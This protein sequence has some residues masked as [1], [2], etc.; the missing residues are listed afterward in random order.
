MRRFRSLMAVMTILFL[1]LA[2]FQGTA[3]AQ[4]RNLIGAN[5]QKASVEIDGNILDAEAYIVDGRTLVP[6][7]KIFET[8][9]CVIDWNPDTWTVTATCATTTIVLTVDEPTAHKNGQPVTLAVPPVLIDSR[10]FVPLRFVSEAL[11]AEVGWEQAEWKA[12][13]KTGGDCAL[14]P[15]QVHEGDIKPGGETWGRCGSPHVVKGTFYVQGADSPILS[16]QEGAVVRFAAGASIEV[17]A[18]APGGLMVY[19]TPNEPIVFTADTSGPQAGFWKGIR[20]YNQALQNNTA[21]ENARFEYAGERE[22]GALYIEGWEKTTEVTLKNVE[23]KNSLYAGLHMADQARLRAGSHGININGT[24]VAGDEG[25]FPIITAVFGSHNLP[26]GEFKGNAVNAV[27]INEQ[28]GSSATVAANTT[29]R[30]IS[31]PYAISQDVW[32]EGNASPTLTIEPGVITLWDANAGLVVGRHAPGTLVADGAARPE[33][34]GEWFTRP[35]GGGEWRVGKPELDLGLNLANAKSLEPGCALC[36]N[37]RAIVF[38]AWTSSPDRGAWNGVQIMGQAGDKSLLNGVVI[39]YAGKEEDYNAG[40]YAE[41]TAGRAVKFQLSN[42]MIAGAARSGMEFYG[43]V[44]IKEGSTGNYFVN[45]GWPIRM[46][47]D[48]VGYLPAGQTFAENDK[49]VISIW[50]GG[51]S[52]NLTKTATWRNHGIPYRMETTVYIGGTASPVLT[53]E[54]GTELLFVNDTGITVGSSEGMGSLVAVGAAGKPIKF[55]GESG[56]AGAWEGLSFTGEAGAGNRLEMVTIEYA[57][58]A[59]SISDD[60][61]GFIKNTTIRSSKEMGIYRSYGSD[62]TSFATGL[63]NQFE[64]NAA[65]ESE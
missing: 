32:V 37:N 47:P 35:E 5:L 65:D 45:N 18:R 44:Q 16:I 50:S 6:L 24:T 2:A 13:I 55:T 17:G 46:A 62:G 51:S 36:G 28:G 59:V 25:G 42:S 21:I 60:L 10:T 53:I 9:G 63:G 64:G 7:R 56:R 27:N 26:R 40:V 22:F 8:L 29:W 14:A 33:G 4:K 58:V 12:T 31:I 57:N 20:I 39:A 48:Q 49:Q 41:S 15:F 61:G 3:M 19:G 23:I 34:G 38:G 43:N 54:P 11:G 52:E 30:N 1:L